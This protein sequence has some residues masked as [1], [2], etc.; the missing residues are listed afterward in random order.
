MYDAINRGYHRANGEILAHINCDEQY[1]PGALRE[2]RDFFDRNPHLDVLLAG[3]IVVDGNGEYICHR[4]AMVPKASHI[5]FRFPVLTSSLFIR[6]R[7]I[8]ERG[9]FFDTRW[10]DLGDLHWMRAL[11][12]EKVSIGVF[13]HFTSSFSDTGE[14]MNLKPNAIRE[15]SETLGMTPRLA[16]LFKPAIIAHHRLRRL[17]AGHFFLGPTKYSIYTLESPL[18]R[19]EFAVSRPTAVWWNRYYSSAGSRSTSDLVT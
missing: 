9:I 19:V 18:R 4:H 1:L 10:R 2:V 3:T 8:H 7:V 5:W 14:N 11:L 13:N 16:R 15:R 12:R 17:A 6:R